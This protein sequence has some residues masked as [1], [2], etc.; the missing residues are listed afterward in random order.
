M[1]LGPD[2]VVS[3]QAVL[4]NMETG[5]EALIALSLL[6]SGEGILDDGP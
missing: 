5:E 6:T 4:R 1:I 3:G 2:E